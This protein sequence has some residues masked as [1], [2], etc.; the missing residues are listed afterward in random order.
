MALASALQKLEDYSTAR[1][2]QVNPAVSHLFIV[3]PLGDPKRQRQSAY[4]DDDPMTSGFIGGSLFSSHP[5]IEK[6]IE[7]L[8]EIARTTGNFS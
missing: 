5:P 7:R 6:R 1:P 4:G 3:N 8:N 2:M